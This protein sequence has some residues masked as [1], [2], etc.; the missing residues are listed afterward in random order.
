MGS[1][2]RAAVARRSRAACGRAGVE[3]TLGD[4]P[5]RV[6]DRGR[7]RRGRRRGA[8]PR[9]REPRDD[10]RRAVER[11]RVA[12]DAAQPVRDLR[13]PRRLALT[14]WDGARA[15]A[16]RAPARARAAA[17]ALLPATPPARR[18]ETP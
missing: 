9:A 7:E 11:R 5:L 3:R 8:G 16:C 13:R 17:R 14:R 18:R 2:D 12:A 6:L 4:P 10:P 15:R 1:P